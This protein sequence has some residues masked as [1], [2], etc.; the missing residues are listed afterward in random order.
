MLNIEMVGVL[1]RKGPR[2]WLI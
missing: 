2:N 1:E